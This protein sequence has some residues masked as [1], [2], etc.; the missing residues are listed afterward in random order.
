MTLYAGSCFSTTCNI[1]GC[2]LCS[3]WTAPGPVV[4]LTCQQGFIKMNGYCMIPNCNNTAVPNC[5][6]CI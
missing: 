6:N 1:N 4:C 3:S 2:L 5:A